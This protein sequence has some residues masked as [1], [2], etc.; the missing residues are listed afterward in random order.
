M[1]H[2]D[3]ALRRWIVD[4]G[5]YVHDAI[6][7]SSATE[8]GSRG[9]VAAAAINLEELEARSLVV[10]PRRLHL[11]NAAAV[12]CCLASEVSRG[13]DSFWLPYL[14]TLPHTPPNPWLCSGPDLA[15][16]LEAMAEAAAA[17][18]MAEAAAAA[19]ATEAAAAQ[20]RWAEGEAGSS[21]G[22]RLSRGS[23][24][25]EGEEEEVLE[26]GGTWGWEPG[27][28]GSDRS[29][30]A[31]AVEA[32][33]RRYRGL[34]EEVLEVVGPD[35]AAL[36]VDPDG[37]MW[38][39]G[40]VVSRSLGSGRSSGLLPFIDMA[41]HHAAAR[42]PMMML[43]DADRL[44]FAVTSI[45]GGELAPLGAGQELFI[46]YQAEDMSPLRAWLKW[47]FVPRCLPARGPA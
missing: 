12:A 10:V 42:P 15:V 8:C 4:H 29:G 13:A 22:Y 47:G 25:E 9:L 2:H 37:L 28:G 43:D 33:R 34:A 14:R 19:A 27:R 16:A 31:A 6:S 1:A 35:A 26:A 17:E 36:R 46:S 41:N 44:V 21:D 45:R 11:D 20:S 18:A 30:W 23:E 32:A 24:G 3:A 39:L 40:Q 38:A 5:G 7:V